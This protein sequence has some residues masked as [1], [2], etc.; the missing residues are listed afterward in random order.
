[1]D[2]ENKQNDEN[3][4]IKNNINGKSPNIELD[5]PEVLRII[6]NIPDELDYLPNEYS[7][8]IQDEDIKI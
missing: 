6:K 4:E 1:M 2:D 3:S 5:S 8:F 7:E